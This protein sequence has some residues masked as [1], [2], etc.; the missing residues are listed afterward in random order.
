V[1]QPEGDADQHNNHSAD[2]QLRHRLVKFDG[3][4]LA[5][6][7]FLHGQT[8]ADGQDAPSHANSCNDKEGDEIR[9]AHIV[10]G[11]NKEAGNRAKDLHHD[12]DQEDLIDHG[13]EGR[14]EGLM[15]QH[16]SEDVVD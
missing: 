6:F 8:C 7:R 5:T 2:E 12:K 11:R 1:D 14:K 13:D 4:E 10:S 9:D 15:Q 3:V 16:R